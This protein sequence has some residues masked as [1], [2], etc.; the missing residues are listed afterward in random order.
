MAISIFNKTSIFILSLSFMLVLNSYGQ[1]VSKYELFTTPA[2][3]YAAIAG[4][5]VSITNKDEDFANGLPIGFDFWYLGV[6]HTKFSVSTNGF[7]ALSQTLTSTMPT[8][9][10]K[11]SATRNVIAPL[12]DD[13]AIFGTGTNPGIRYLTEGA[14]GSRILTVQWREM[15]WNKTSTSRISFQAKLYEGTGEIRFIYINGTGSGS[16][17]SP[18]ASIGISGPTSGQFASVTP[19]TTAPVANAAINYTSEKSNIATKPANNVN[20]LFK[21]T[22]VAAPTNLTFTAIGPNHLTLNWTIVATDNIGYVIY[23]STN[24][25]TGFSQSG[26]MVG[27]NATSYT[28]TGLD[29]MTTYYYK[30]YAVRETLSA[31]STVN[32]TTI[33]SC[34]ETVT[35]GAVAN[36]K[37]NGDAN[38]AMG[39]NAG[40]LQNN[41]T[42]SADRFQVAN[43]AYT[44]NGTNQFLATATIYKTDVTVFTTSC[45]FKTTTNAGGVLIAFGASQTSTTNTTYTHGNQ[46]YMT[47]DGSIYFGV[48]KPA[49]NSV[50]TVNSAAGF[51]DGRW[52]QVTAVLSAS[53]MRL[54][55]DGVKVGTDNPNTVT[56]YFDG[57]WRVGHMRMNN[58]WPGWNAGDRVQAFFAGTIDD[59][60][61]YHKGL[62]DAEAKALYP[63]ALIANSTG[64]VCAGYPFNLT[65]ATTF[66]GAT[67]QWTRPDGTTFSGQNHTGLMLNNASVGVYKV[68]VTSA[69]GCVTTSAT[70]VSFTNSPGQWAGKISTAW[71]NPDNWCAGTL[72]TVATNVTIPTTGPTFN[73]T[74]T[75]VGL[76]DSI[77]VESNRAL[78]ISGSGDLQVAGTITKATTGTITASAGKVTLNGTAAQEIP[79]N[80]FASNLIKDL[81]LNNTAGVTL[82]GTL[83]LTGLLTPSAGIFQTGGNLTLAS[84]ETATAIVATIP[85][86][87]SVRGSVKVERFLKGGAMNPYRTYRMLSSP[88]YDNITDFVNTNV[89]GNRSAKFSQLIDDMIISGANGAAGGFDVTHNN[90][91]SAWTYSGGFTPITNINAAVNAGKGMYVFF[92][93]NRN[94]FQAKTNAP[95]TNP[96][97]V[98]M[99]FDGV[100]IQ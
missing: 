92:R 48:Y 80:V 81:T 22:A 32:A 69:T 74:L 11:L 21:S 9:D 51:N 37:L 59:V 6:K 97:D 52:H 64:P 23:R 29:Q 50:K 72:P 38:D 33:I 45:W 5:S 56:Q 100:L 1:N 41:P 24:A 15:E 76:S 10:L 54:Y 93:G 35:G 36:Y 77:T 44:F 30:V 27:A 12:W 7:M 58:T 61:I 62:S 3:S 75:T 42:A 99:N 20:Y 88:V 13:L 2:V 31:T 83:R 79:A 65:A 4:T 25:T 28:D 19:A 96:E 95:Y 86:N 43:K 14:E 18:S 26:A 63:A 57:Y 34:L 47:T 90:Q 60:L 94:N 55:L 8:N 46:L 67:Y 17:T 68:S 66:A 84:S 87:T 70:R 53:G 16:P 71:A 73:P 82:N 91:V 98:V 85:L 78:T 49:D 39:L 40:A 89:E